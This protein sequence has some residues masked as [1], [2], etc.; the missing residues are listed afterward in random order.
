MR[1]LNG[2]NSQ[3]LARITGNTVHS[4]ARST[5]SSFD[6]VKHVRVRLLRWLGEILRG[7]TGDPNTDRLLFKAVKTQYTM[8]CPGNLFMDVPSHENFNELIHF[9]RDKSF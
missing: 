9:T 3:M 6:L 2:C 4:E 8:N 1:K 7:N 5:T